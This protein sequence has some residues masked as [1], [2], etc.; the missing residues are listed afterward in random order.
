MYLYYYKSNKQITVENGGLLDQSPNS[1]DGAAIG[2]WDCFQNNQHSLWHLVCDCCSNLS[3]T[4]YRRVCLDVG[5]RAVPILS[6]V[7]SYV[8]CLLCHGNPAVRIF[9]DCHTGPREREQVSTTETQ[10][11]N[12]AGVIWTAASPETAS[13]YPL[14]WPK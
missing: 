1:S 12:A 11:S 2:V 14:L 5:S 10:E 8:L 4:I 7:Q 3:H 13:D 9:T 6:P